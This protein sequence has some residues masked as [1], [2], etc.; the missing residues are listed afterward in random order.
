MDQVGRDSLVLEKM[1]QLAQE[2]QVLLPATDDDVLSSLRITWC[3]EAHFSSDLAAGILAVGE[4][5][6]SQG[7]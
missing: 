2:L 6:T 3:L 1:L 7:A 4:D 5:R